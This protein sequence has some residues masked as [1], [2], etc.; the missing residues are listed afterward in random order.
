MQSETFSR[1]KLL[2]RYLPV[3]CQEFQGN[4]FQNCSLMLLLCCFC[5]SRG[6]LLICTKIQDVEINRLT[7]QICLSKCLNK[8]NYFRQERGCLTT[9]QWLWI[10]SAPE[11]KPKQKTQQQKKLGQKLVFNKMLSRKSPFCYFFIGIH[12]MQGW[13]TTTSMKLQEKEAQKD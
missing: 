1:N 10:A 2:Q 8:S 4:Y 3:T 9:G 6:T 7:Y 5:K 11:R 12:S 13:T